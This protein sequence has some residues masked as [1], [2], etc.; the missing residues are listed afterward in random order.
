MTD[1]ELTDC[2]Q[3]LIVVIAPGQ[4]ILHKFY[5]ADSDGICCE[6]VSMGWGED[7]FSRKKSL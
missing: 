5:S 1:Y 6:E 3:I 2:F 4:I 7:F